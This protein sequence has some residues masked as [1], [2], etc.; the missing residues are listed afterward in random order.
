MGSLFSGIGGLELGLEWSG[1]AETRWQCEINPFCLSILAKHWPLA[2]RFTDVRSLLSPPHVD[3]LCGGFPCQDVSQAARGRN[4]GLSGEKSGLW[5]EYA[6]VVEQVKPGAVVV[7]NVESGASR[8]L[9]EVRACLGRLGYRT[10][11]LG[12]SAR[13][14]GAPHAR[15]RVFVVGYA[16]RDGE[17]TLQVDG[18]MAR[19][20]PPSGALRA[21]WGAPPKRVRMADGVSAGLDALRAL[22]NSVSPQVSYIVGRVILDELRLCQSTIGLAC[23]TPK[24]QDTTEGE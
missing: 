3:L 14:V 20:S 2:E 19:L 12:V 15:A 5:R 16:D 13:D 6:R 8:W 18:E 23:V 21:G 17:P 10:R 22:G 4:P 1:L 9:P 11:A 24:R 7:E